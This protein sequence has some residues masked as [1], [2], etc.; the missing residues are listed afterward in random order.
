MS[1]KWF[2]VKAMVALVVIVLLATGGYAV[3]R[4]GWSQGYAAGQL[5]TKGEEGATIPPGFHPGRPFG[6]APHRVS[7]LL[8]VILGLLFLALTGKLIRFVIWGAAFHPMMAGSWPRHWRRTARWHRMHGPTPPWC[9]DWD[10]PCD[11]EAEGSSEEP[12][13]ED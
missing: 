12:N 11:E 4:T 8:T 9:W 2:L 1:K 3:Y 13:A 6:F 5:A 10:E 7:L